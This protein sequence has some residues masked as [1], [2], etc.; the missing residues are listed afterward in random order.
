MAWASG[1]IAFYLIVFSSDCQPHGAD[2]NVEHQLQLYCSDGFYNGAAAMAF[3]T[4]EKS[5]RSFFHDPRGSFRLRTLLFFA[6]PYYFLSCWTYG[7]SVP[8]GLFIPALL[9]G[10]AWGRIIGDG[11]VSIGFTSIDPGK[12]ALMGA[13]A[14][15]GGIVR[16][17]IS[18]TVILM[19]ATGDL[20]LGLPIMLVLI[21]AQRV[22]NFFNHGIYDS[23]IH[24]SRVPLLEWEPPLLSDVIKATDVMSHPVTTMRCNEN[25]GVIVDILRRETHN[26]FP[27]VDDN[28][29]GYG[30]GSAG[31]GGS[32]GANCAPIFAS[33]Q[34]QLRG[35]VPSIRLPGFGRLRGLILRSQLTFLLKHR[36]FNELPESAQIKYA[37]SLDD[38]AKLYPRYFDIDV[39]FYDVCGLL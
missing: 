12:C 29:P 1:T 13:A 24:M 25:V 19:E 22:G 5:V 27:V 31:G 37:L 20:T 16:M 35:A 21:I 32:V 33:Y 8:S 2:P 7:L 3:Q 6:A 36:V 11:L 28:D 9:S 38:Y 17:T 18:L 4:P 14:H 30:P 23:H 10:A 15:L 39:S 26:G 34:Y